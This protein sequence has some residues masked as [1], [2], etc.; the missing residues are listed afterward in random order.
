MRPIDEFIFMLIIQ[1]LAH[2]GICGSGIARLFGFPPGIGNDTEPHYSFRG[3][4]LVI[5]PYLNIDV[6]IMGIREALGSGGRT[7]GQ[8][9]FSV[10]N[11][12]EMTH[13]TFS[14]LMDDTAALEEGQDNSLVLYFDHPEE[15]GWR[16]IHIRSDH[17]AIGKGIEDFA[18]RIELL[19]DDGMQ[20]AVKA[21]LSAKKL[22]AFVAAISQEILPYSAVFQEAMTQE[23]DL[24][25]VWMTSRLTNHIMS[26]SLDTTHLMTRLF[27]GIASGS[28][29]D[30]VVSDFL[31]NLVA[32]DMESRFYMVD[33]ESPDEELTEIC[34]PDFVR[35]AKDVTETL[36]SD[37]S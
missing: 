20:Q 24:S 37:K 8:A 19:R 1:F 33:V 28:G 34:M 25:A 16:K 36:T 14:F 4:F 27:R 23:T 9:T 2:G 30:P 6:S 11:E 26:F 12:G 15:V 5:S 13:G 10:A 29:L 31:R 7:D 18:P 21:Q 22:A 35:D 17:G 32:A 3:R